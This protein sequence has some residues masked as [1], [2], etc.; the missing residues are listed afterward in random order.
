MYYLRHGICWHFVSS[1]L[2]RFLWF[3]LCW[4]ISD[5]ILGI[6]NVMN[7]GSDCHLLENVD[8]FISA[9]N[10]FRFRLQVPHL[11]WMVFLVSV[12]FGRQVIYPSLAPCSSQSWVVVYPWVQFSKPLAC[13]LGSDP[14]MCSSELSPDIDTQFN[15]LSFLRLLLF[16]IPTTFSG[17]LGPLPS[18]SR[19]LDRGFCFPALPLTSQHC[20]CLWGP[21]GRG[22]K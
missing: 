18:L 16:I 3:V 9:G 15:D 17:S 2:W 19:N 5:C 6:W 20:I 11:P 7:S 22:Q 4:V 12:S 21:T 13:G 10:G 1:E 14:H 8:Y